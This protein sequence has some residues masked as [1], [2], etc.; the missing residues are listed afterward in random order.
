M[1]VTGKAALLNF[2]YLA[3]RG[4]TTLFQIATRLTR[5][6]APYNQSRTNCLTPLGPPIFRPPPY[7]CNIIRSVKKPQRFT[8]PLLVCSIAIVMVIVIVTWHY[9][10]TETQQHLCTPPV[11]VCLINQPKTGRQ[12]QPDLAVSGLISLSQSFEAFT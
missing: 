7:R 12:L 8:A 3:E 4:L 2:N 1:R 11:S 5:I 6:G 9:L 10:L